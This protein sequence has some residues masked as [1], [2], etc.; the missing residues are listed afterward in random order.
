MGVP[1]NGTEGTQAQLLVASGT[2]LPQADL[3]CPGFTFTRL[4]W[5]VHDHRHPRLSVG[6]SV[7]GTAYGEPEGLEQRVTAGHGDGRSVMVPTT[8]EAGDSVDLWI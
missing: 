6:R 5:Y 1:S 3:E 4:T 2:S 7:G 8:S